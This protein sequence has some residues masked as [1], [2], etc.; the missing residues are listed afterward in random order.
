MNQIKVFGSLCYATTLQNHR[1]KFDGRAIKTVFLGY[2]I[3]YKGS[4]LLDLHSH[5]IFISRH[6]TYH[7]NILPYESQNPY[8][9]HR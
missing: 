5:E 1:T 3:G 4:I 9:T 7:E 6:V 2:D 8:A